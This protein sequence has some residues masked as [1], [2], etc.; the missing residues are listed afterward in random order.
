VALDSLTELNPIFA[1]IH[2]HRAAN[3]KLF[4]FNDRLFQQ[5]FSQYSEK[6]GLAP[7]RPNLYALR[8]GGASDDMASCR[9]SPREVQLRGRWRT[10]MSLRRYA[11]VVRLTTQAQKAPGSVGDY[12]RQVEQQVLAFFLASASNPRSLPRPPFLG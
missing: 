9:R 4:R 6:F 1:T 8:H 12:G 10:V 2:R 7:L 5:R 11:K 3:E